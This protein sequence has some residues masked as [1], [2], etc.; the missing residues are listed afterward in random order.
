MVAP[1]TLTHDEATGQLLCLPE[2]Q[3]AITS[4]F[5]ILPC[6]LISELDGTRL[7]QQWMSLNP[8]SSTQQKG[9]MAVFYPTQGRDWISHKKDETDFISTVPLN[10][11]TVRPPHGSLRPHIER[12]VNTMPT[13]TLNDKV[14]EAKGVF[15]QRW[16]LT[17]K[18]GRVK[19]KMKYRDA[20]VYI[21]P[22][23]VKKF[24]AQNHFE[25][26]SEDVLGWWAKS[27]WQNG[28]GEKLG[29]DEVLNERP[30]LPGNMEDSQ[31]ADDSA[32]ATTHSPTNAPVSTQESAIGFASRVGK[33]AN[34]VIRTSSVEVPPLLAYVQPLP[35]PTSPQALIR[36]V[37]TSH[38]LLSISL[39]LAK[40]ESHPLSHEH[41]VHPSVILEQQARISQEDSLV[42]E[43]VKIGMRS[44]IKSSVIGANCEIGAYARI[45][46][47]LLMDGVTVGDGVQLTGCIIGKRAR[48][49]GTARQES[50]APADGEKKKGKKQQEAD[51]NK[52][53][54]QDCEVAPHFVVE[55]G[56]DAKR[57]KMTAFEMVSTEDEGEGE[58]EGEDEDE[59][60]DE[61]MEL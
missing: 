2:I 52:T 24:A 47:C 28:L 8:L 37:D 48:I 29:L 60:E 54:L 16:Q 49:E 17:G 26:I 23:W 3:K 41:K 10:A 35:T 6:D 51:D 57:E 7:V 25:S 9:G 14:E 18:Y 55:A 45:T 39:H 40:Q 27:Q 36:R 53:T 5:V 33:N 46:G 58:G 13:D 34:S 22:L 4:D 59:N 20:H 43:N 32:N 42:A 38:A 19:L 21:F 12:V 11:S 30:H 31:F 50:V 61:E 56:T 44:A 1:E 15:E